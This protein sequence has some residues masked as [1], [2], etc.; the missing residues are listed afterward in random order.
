M[1]IRD[2]SHPSLVLL[3]QAHAR[4]GDLDA[5]AEHM[6][7][8]YRIPGPRTNTGARFVE[9]LVRAG[10]VDE[11]RAVVASDPALAEHPRV[12]KAFSE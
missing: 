4:A 7:L 10:R 2:S 12:R 5:A 8:A 11:A 3:S 1:C 6:G 9:L